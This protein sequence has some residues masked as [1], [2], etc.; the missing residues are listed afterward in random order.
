MHEPTVDRPVFPTDYGVAT[1]NA[2]LLPFSHAQERLER[3]LVYWVSTV[4]PNRRPHTSPLWGVWLDNT[5]YFDG[6]PETRRGQNLAANPAVT[7]HLESGGEGKDVLVLEGNAYQQR[8]AEL[9]DE[10]K[11]QIA[12][13]YASKYSAEGYRPEPNQWDAGGLYAVRVHTIIAWTKFNTDST[14]WRFS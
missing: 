3:A 6:S 9:A 8:G 1:D 7:I 4:R 5:L 2:G 11:Q 14:R 12:A 10:L 13:Q